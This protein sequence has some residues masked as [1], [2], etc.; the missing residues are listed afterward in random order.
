MISPPRAEDAQ[1]MAEALH[2]AARI[3]RRTW[4]NPPVGAVVVSGD[5]RVVGRGAHHGPGLPH[6]EAVALGEAAEAARGGTLYVTLEPCNHQGRTP[7]CAPA[8]AAS[9]VGRLVAAV[10]DPNPSVPGGGLRLLR[11]AGIEITLGVLAEPALHL[12]WP[13]V[14]TGAFER[15]YVLLKT[16]DSL[17]GRF[18]PPARD[19]Q[20]PSPAYLTGLEA[21]RD[22]HRLR[23]WS[24][25]VLVGERTLAADRPQLDGRLVRDGEDD[26]PE[27]EPA[28]GYAD[29]D[30]SFAQIWPLERYFVFA[31]R[32]R[33]AAASR[34]RI[35]LEGGIIVLCDERDG[36]VAPESLLAEAF[37]RGGWAIMIEGGPTLA[38]SFLA[39]GLVDRWIRYT[40]PILLGAGARWPDWI[41]DPA[42]P[43]RGQAADAEDYSLTS[44]D[45]CGPDL[46]VVY[47]RL[48]FAQVLAEL[49][50]ETAQGLRR[51]EVA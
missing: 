48:P 36:R 30:L 25:L 14:A 2:L 50:V 4:P 44:C 47:D 43:D 35:E 12:I 26:C 34:A 42:E 32:T 45:R 38:S 33:A 27:S 39:R 40:A 31:G 37:S 1:F 18:A 24:D 22:V 17:D 21:R 10:G 6:A 28:A 46:K 29:S 13:F 3:P 5:G 51:G 15:P 41:A 20:G 16:A 11:D 19:G 23:R 7:P 8:V 49:T 9:G